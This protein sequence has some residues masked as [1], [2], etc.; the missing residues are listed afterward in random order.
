MPENELDRLMSL[1]PLELSSQDIDAIILY[2]R[3][4][5]LSAESGAKPK[6]GG[7][8]EKVDL[9]AIGLGSKKPEIKR[10][11]IT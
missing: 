10:R 4:A 1:D 9:A 2:H 8:V 6:R 5:R 11:K 3:R 7:T